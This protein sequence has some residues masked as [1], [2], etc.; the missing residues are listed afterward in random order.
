LRNWNFP[1][2]LIDIV[3]AHENPIHINDRDMADYVDVLTMANLR[4]QEAKD[5]AWKNVGA[6]ERLGYYPG[7]CRNF[8]SLQGDQIITIKGMLG[9]GVA[10]PA[11]SIQE[12]NTEDTGLLPAQT[13]QAKSG[14]LNNL[15]RFFKQ[16]SP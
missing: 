5:V 1:N 16:P 11:K 15:S 10:L 7:D 3:A 13:Q 12:L 2:A 9:L 6:A 4:V 14:F 8:F